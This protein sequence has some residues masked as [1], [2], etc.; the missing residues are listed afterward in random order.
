MF[1]PVNACPS[2]P[3]L[4]SNGCAHRR[5]AGLAVIVLAALLTTACSSSNGAS[6]NTPKVIPVR[7]YP[8]T[9]E[10]TLRRVQAVGS[11]FALEESTLSAEVEGIVSKVLVDVGDTVSA[12]QPLILLDQR[13]LQ[14]EVDRQQAAVRQ[15][16]AQLGIGPNDPPPPDSRKTAS[17]QHAEADFF[18]ADRKF[19]RATELFK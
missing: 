16:R 5:T 15:V 8:V 13:E 10:T 14:F 6:A 9:E 4:T 11:L 19:K 12:G 17:V 2:R 7:I 1:R 3:R 18:D